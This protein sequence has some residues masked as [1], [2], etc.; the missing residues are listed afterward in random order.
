[1]LGEAVSSF[2][3]LEMLAFVPYDVFFM[4]TELPHGVSG[5]ELAA[6]LAQ[7]DDPPALIFLATEEDQAFTAFELGARP[8]TCSGPRTR[9]V[10]PR[11]IE[12]LRP[13]AAAQEG[14]AT[15]PAPC[16]PARDQISEETVQLSMGDDE[17]EI[18]VNALRQAW[19]MSRE[20]LARNRKTSRQPGRP[21]HPH[22]LTP[23]SC[24][25][26]PTRTTAS[27]TRPRTVS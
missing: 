25:W 6:H 20:R 23:R 12:R 3:A 22:S 26:K 18:F 15:D 13:P 16:N 27:C 4:G 7:G 14:R 10:S 2:E 24:T 9:T 17:E 8:T 19:D 5:M 1:M 11:S 21:P